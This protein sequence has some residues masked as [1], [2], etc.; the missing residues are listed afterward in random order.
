M[1]VRKGLTKTSTGKHQLDS[2]GD[3][4][5][6]D[7]GSGCAHEKTKHV[8]RTTSYAKVIGKAILRKD[9][10][11]NSDYK[12]TKYEGDIVRVLHFKNGWYYV[13]YDK[14]CYAYIH[15]SRVILQ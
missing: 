14:G 12:A 2:N 1:V 15:N 7:F 13:E 6:C 3:C 5:Q 8:E 9:A 11:P 10:D 4:T